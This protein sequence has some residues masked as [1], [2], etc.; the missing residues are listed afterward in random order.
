MLVLT[1]DVHYLGLETMSLVDCQSVC[2]SVSCTT[3]SS[4]GCE[5]YNSPGSL[6][7]QNGLYGTGGTFTGVGMM[8]AC[9]SQCFSY[10][11]DPVTNYL[12]QNGCQ[13]YLGTGQTYVSYNSCTGSCES[14]ACDDPC[15]TNANNVSTGLGCVKYI[16]TGATHLT[17]IACTGVCQENWYC[18]TAST[19]DSCDGL[20]WSTITS[21]DIDD[22]I[23]KIASTPGWTNIL[24]QDFKFLYITIP[25]NATNTCYSGAPANAYWAKVTGITITLSSTIPAVTDAYSWDDVTTFMFQHYPSI[26]I[27]DIED[28]ENIGGVTLTYGWELCSCVDI[29][30]TIGCTNNTTIPANTVGPHA[31]YALAETNCCSATTWSCATNTIIDD[32]DGLTL[33]PGLFT[34][35]E[36]C[37]E[38][39]ASSLTTYGLNV[40]TFKCEVMPTTSTPL[41]PC[42]VGPNYGQL[43]RLTGITSSIS[44][45]VSNNYTS[46]TGYTYAL[47]NLNPAVTN[48]VNGLP[49]DILQ[50]EVQLI[51]NYASSSVYYGWADCECD[52][53]YS[54]GCVELFDGTGA[55][56]SKTHCEL[57]CCTATTWNCVS[58]T[59]YLPICLLK[60]HHGDTNDTTSL[61]EYYRTSSPTTLFGVD[62]WTMATSTPVTWTQVQINM[63]LAGLPWIWQD[64]YVNVSASNFYPIVYLYTIFTSTNKWRSTIP[65]MG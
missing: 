52:N 61:L 59:E 63:A 50:D 8:A 32:C 22:H 23:D 55:F 36:G 5:V 11:C 2:T 49:L 27:E 18:T 62:T 21:G 6:S 24:F 45:I 26:L 9:Q 35:A 34:D 29:P 15:V 4:V 60:T 17:L 39:F 3:S 1:Q 14:W 47:Q 30:C 12:T 54:C 43:I 20:T 40:T 13:Q 25:T 44:A 7:D 38:W 10:N 16:N 31:T 53:P 37:Y 46:L 57:S 41:A 56:T 42:E 64:C 48:A 58:G 65:N 28:I 19:I 51:S 33:V